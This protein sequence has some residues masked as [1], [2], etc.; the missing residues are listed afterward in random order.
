MR[1]LFLKIFAIFWVAQSLIFV[2]SIMLIVRQRFPGPVVSD[3]LDSILLHNAQLAVRAYEANGCIGF[4]N[5]PSRYEPSGAALLDQQRRSADASGPGAVVLKQGQSLR[6]DRAPDD[7]ALG[8]SHQNERVI[9]L[10]AAE[11]NGAPNCRR[12]VDYRQH[13]VRRAELSVEPNQS[14]IAAR[15]SGWPVVVEAETGS[16]FEFDADRMPGIAAAIVADQEMHRLGREVALGQ[17]I[18]HAMRGRQYR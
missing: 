11:H 16:G 17:L 2:I 9:L 5:D 8:I 6:I 15:R 12:V 13:T 3:A 14:P 18:E 7:L 4:S 10:V 1:G